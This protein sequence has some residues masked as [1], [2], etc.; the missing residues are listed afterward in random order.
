MEF[1]IAKKKKIK[2][3][4]IFI[5]SA[6]QIHNLV[7]GNVNSTI[8]TFLFLFLW[9]L[10]LTSLQSCSHRLTKEGGGGVL[11]YLASWVSEEDMIFKALSL[12]RIYNFT[13]SNVKLLEQGVFLYRVCE[14]WRWAVYI[15][16]TE[17]YF[18]Q[19]NLIQWCLL[20]KG[21]YNVKW[22]VFIIIMK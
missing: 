1:L 3:L 20:K 19:I 6:R 22:V 18:L 13:F 7:F 17:N 9:G 5:S 2:V 8:L 15:W 21:H 11:P 12:N 14:G 16:G 4:F 10:F